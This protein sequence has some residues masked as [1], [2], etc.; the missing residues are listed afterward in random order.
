MVLI[1][2]TCKNEEEGRKLA[3]IIIEHHMAS[4]VD[5]WPIRSTYRWGGEI[6]ED[7]EV[8]VLIKTLESKL[9]SIEDLIVQ[10]HAYATPFIGAV[11]VRRINHPYKEWMSEVIY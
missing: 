5:V 8:E 9:Q 2:T 4:C 1:Y 6:K 7:Q 11:D 10:N 3:R